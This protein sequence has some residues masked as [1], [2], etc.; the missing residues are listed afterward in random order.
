M[1]AEQREPRPVFRY[2]P[3]RRTALVFIGTGTHGAYHAGV[4]RALHEA[5][6]KIDVVAGQGV[7]AAVALLTAI[8]GG[9]RLWEADSLWRGDRPRRFYGWKGSLRTIGVLTAVL[10]VALATPAL[11]ILLGQ[12]V[13]SVGLPSAILAI[14]AATAIAATIG[15][16]A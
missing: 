3:E 10:F 5:G 4:L 13:G 8:D 6:V 7:G 12:P 15:L 11:L 9:T 16:G 14:A 1:S 2:S